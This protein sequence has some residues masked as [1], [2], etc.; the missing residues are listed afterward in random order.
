VRKAITSW[1]TSASI[2]ATRATSKPAR[3]RIASSAS[4]GTT[5]RSAST[6]Q[7]AISTASQRR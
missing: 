3:E 7:A 4:A 2:S 6:S 5:P 1:R